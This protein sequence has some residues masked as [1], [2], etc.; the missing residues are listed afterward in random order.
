MASFRSGALRRWLLAWV[1]PG[2]AALVFGSACEIPSRPQCTD[3]DACASDYRCVE[4][5]CVW[6]PLPRLFVYADRQ[7]ARLGDVVA[8]D[9]SASK[10]PDGEALRF[11]FR[12][13][14]EEVAELTVSE[15]DP[16]KAELHIVQAHRAVSV[17]LRAVTPSGR[18]A[19]EELTIHPRN[20]R[21]RVTLRGPRHLQPGEA[22][23]FV[24]EAVDPEGDAL[25]FRWRLLEG[26]GELRSDGERAWLEAGEEGRF[27]LEVTVSDGMGGSASA[28]A[29]F[30]LENLPP[31][32]KL[33][34]ALAV[35]HRCEE[36]PSSCSASVTLRAEIDD[37]GPL[38]IEWSLV[39]RANEAVTAKLS[40][41][42]TASPR[43]T[44]RCEPACAIAG[45]YVF[46]VEVEDANGA[47]VDVELPLEVR[48][49]SPMILA[50]DGRELEHRYLGPGYR[51]VREEGEGTVWFDPDGDPILPGSVRWSSDV[52][53]VHFV[54]PERWDTIVWAEG[55]LAQ[56]REALFI[57]VEAKD[58]NGAPARHGAE[59]V[60]GNR[61]P[62]VSWGGDLREGYVVEQ[63]MESFRREIDLS[64]AVVYDLD[65]DPVTLSL[66]LDGSMPGFDLVGSDGWWTL[67]GPLSAL[68]VDVP[69]V[70]LASDSLGGESRV[71]AAVRISNRP[72]IFL[73]GNPESPIDVP[74]AEACGWICC[75]PEGCE[76]PQPLATRWRD[77]A[78]G[79]WVWSGEFVVADPDRTALR[80]LHVDGDSVQVRAE[81][82]WRWPPVALPCIDQGPRHVCP[83]EIRVAHPRSCG[84]EVE[85]TLPG[86]EAAVELEIEDVRGASS[87][88]SLV[89]RVP[90]D[91]CP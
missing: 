40:G 44:L 84:D 78:L 71:H 27:T 69:V 11:E 35:E 58:L 59:L 52:D 49:R 55:L 1:V 25:S 70:L 48:N 91:L 28:S 21:P 46:R 4:T 45:T 7:E 86:M 17:T 85:G 20:G 23:A 16:A 68:D 83:V 43:V 10:H 79:P 72:P 39:E 30:D 64:Q 57:E 65:G 63:T 50:H 75:D 36:E 62:I 87:K 22:H 18:E 42:D 33:P 9:A 41:G 73:H 82:E 26:E 24:A 14:P 89:F 77:G 6:D 47:R 5:A 76:S 81:G 34:E 8:L 60:M 61:P 15:D 31:R 51:I 3:D 2:G 29:S 12:I 19:E 74:G 90:E 88:R 13:A 37:V 56:L 53:V 54:D 66:L 38:H 32:V 67:K 80:A